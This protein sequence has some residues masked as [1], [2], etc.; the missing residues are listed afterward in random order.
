MALVPFEFPF[1]SVHGRLEVQWG[2]HTLSQTHLNLHFSSLCS[3]R[4]STAWVICEVVMF[5]RI[6]VEGIA[7]DKLGKA[8]YG[9]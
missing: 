4:Q 7:L 9:S 2:G 6:S 3:V 1:F 5:M 8:A